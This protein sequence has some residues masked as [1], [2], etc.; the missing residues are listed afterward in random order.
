MRIPGALSA[1]NRLK[2][3]DILNTTVVGGITSSGTRA[4]LLTALQTRHDALAAKRQQDDFTA[5][6]KQCIT[7]LKKVTVG[8]TGIL[9]DAAVEAARALVSGDKADK[10]IA[11]LQALLPNPTEPKKHHSA[12]TE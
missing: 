1:L 2:A 12:M 8:T 10:L 11:D 4:K 9:T 6:Y 7:N 3:L 5:K